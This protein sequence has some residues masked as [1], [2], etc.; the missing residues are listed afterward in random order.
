MVD[1][2]LVDWFSPFDGKGMTI[3]RVLE[4]FKAILNEKFEISDI[5][6]QKIAIITDD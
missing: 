4:E 5:R 3:E 2:T 1:K 6:N